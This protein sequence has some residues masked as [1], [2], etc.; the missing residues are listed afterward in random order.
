MQL[1]FADSENNES[2]LP[3]EVLEMILSQVEASDLS[4]THLVDHRW[5]DTSLNEYFLRA[6]FSIELA[7][8]SG[9]DQK[10]VER[11]EKLL[12][13]VAKIRSSKAMD[14]LLDYTA[15][16]KDFF[17]QKIVSLYMK[18]AEPKDPKHPRKTK[19]PSALTNLGR[20]YRSSLGV[21][22]DQKKALNLFR[23]ASKKGYAEG[24]YRLAQAYDYGKGTEK[25]SQ[26][27]LKFY[28]RSAE[29]GYAPAQNDLGFV[30]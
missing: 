26:K 11:I 2:K 22:Q 1:T 14:K 13:F 21:T 17:T 27:A 20:L 23:R 25:N 24:L 19:D 28:A 12:F 7:A 30:Y 16:Y 4:N 3:N 18:A 5:R 10:K 15:D 8:L 29:K 6:Y 9:M